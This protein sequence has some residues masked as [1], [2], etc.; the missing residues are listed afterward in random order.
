MALDRRR[1]LQLSGAAGAGAALAGCGGFSTGGDDGGGGDG[2]G[3][4]GGALD[5]VLWGSDAEVAAFQAVA[6]AFEEQEGV[7]VRLQPTPFGEV[8]TTIDTGLQSGSPPDLFRITYTDLGVYSGADVLLDVTDDLPEGYADAFVPSLWR[9]VQ[10]PD[11]QVLG[12]PHHTDTSMVLVDTAALEAAGVGP[13]PTALDQAWTWEQFADAC[14]RLRAALPEDRFPVGVNWQLG[15]AYRWLGFLH[16]AGGRL[17]TDDLSGPAVDSPEG[18]RALEFTRSFFTNRWVPPSTSA[19]GTYVD[20]LF[21]PQTVAMVYAGDFLLPTFEE[22]VQG[23]EYSGTFLPRDQRAAAELGG[24]AVVATREGS[25]TQAAS[26]FL[27]FLASEEQMQAFCTA[28]TVLPTRTSLTNRD[29][30][31]RLRPDLMEL[32]VQQATQIPEDLVAQVTVPQFSAINN[33][34]VERLESAFVGGADTSEVLAG[35][36]GD[37]ETALGS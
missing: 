17:L 36:S 16:Q 6:D 31:Y 34:L 8:L 24:N 1:F 3:G 20:E 10:G 11:G 21:P 33:A 22:T 12:V 9:A 15:G 2:G 29:L 23:F 13:L 27:Q 7:Q 18:R 4:G 14:D 26:R 32:Y 19:K 35:L 37:I 25:N 30:G 28:T 5:F